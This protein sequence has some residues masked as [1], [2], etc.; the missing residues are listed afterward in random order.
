MAKR[1]GNELILH[2]RVVTT[3]DLPGVPEGTRGRVI[4]VDGWH[5]RDD[6]DWIRYRV[7]FEIGGPN[8]TDVGSVSR[9]ELRRVDRHGNSLEGEDAS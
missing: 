9:N 3:A 8:G 5:H 4:L 1:T 7:L 6:R 2:D